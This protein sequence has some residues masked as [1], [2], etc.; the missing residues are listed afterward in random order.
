[1]ARYTKCGQDKRMEGHKGDAQ[2][3]NLSRP[4]ELNGPPVEKMSVNPHYQRQERG[5]TVEQ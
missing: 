1:M 4:Q 5:H 3:A 2:Q